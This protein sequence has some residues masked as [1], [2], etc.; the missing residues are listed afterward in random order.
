MPPADY[1][2]HLVADERPIITDT[3]TAARVA[4][5]VAHAGRAGVAE[6]GLTDHVYRFAAARD[7]MTAPGWVAGATAD[8]AVYVNAVREAAEA[9]LPV[10]LGLEVD[11]VPG[12]QADIA[13]LRAAHPWDYFLGSYHW[14]DVHEID[15]A[16]N[17]V[18]EATPTETV[19]RRYVDGFC[20][21][22]TSGLYDSMAHPD[23]AK[24]FGHRLD[25]E[26]LGLYAEMADAAAAAGVCVEVSTGGLRKPAAEMYPAPA[27]LRMFRER[28]V[29]VT[30]GSDAHE[31]DLIGYRFD[32]ALALLAD[33]GYRSVTLFR[34][35]ERLQA[36]LV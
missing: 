29:P 30:L 15:H 22:A 36:P 35:G 6:I 5:Y 28:G 25:P 21:A 17:S 7:W 14:M 26:P 31:P 20:A 13:G 9:G 32:A 11:W 34:R 1:H 16:A 24:V 10:R 18:W 19:W 12:R 33:A 8:L 3:Y 27:L 23:L 2:M 4:E